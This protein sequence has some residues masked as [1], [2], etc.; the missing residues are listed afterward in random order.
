MLAKCKNLYKFIYVY[1]YI[2]TYTHTH[3]G[4]IESRGN[5]ES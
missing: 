1:I 4:N 5:I 3:I 2:Y